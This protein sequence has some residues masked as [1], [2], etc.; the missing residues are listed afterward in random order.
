MSLFAE[1]NHYCSVFD[2][3]NEGDREKK[4]IVLV[5][6]YMYKEIIVGGWSQPF[7]RKAYR[8]CYTIL[9]QLYW[10]YSCIAGEVFQPFPTHYHSYQ[11][12]II[13]YIKSMNNDCMFIQFISLKAPISFILNDYE[14]DIDMTVVKGL[15]SLPPPDL[16]LPLSLY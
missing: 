14:E 10:L 11:L 2:V 3:G 9:G 15:A 8:K 4:H 16:E 5:V 13:T 7:T 12:I 1:A 6:T